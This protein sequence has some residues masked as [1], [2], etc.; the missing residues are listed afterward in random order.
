MTGKDKC[1][2]LKAVRVKIAALNGIE[3]T[4]NQCPHEGPCPGTCPACEAEA[5]GLLAKLFE[6]ELDGKSINIDMASLVELQGLAGTWDG[7]PPDPS[8][9]DSDNEIAELGYVMTPGFIEGKQGEANGKLRG[10][11]MGDIINDDQLL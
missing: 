6:K 8:D 11:L 1:N 4:P 2:I 7:T 3:Y 9:E 10:T 5:E